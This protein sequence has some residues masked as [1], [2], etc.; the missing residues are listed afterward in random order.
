MS[1]GNTGGSQ[2]AQSGAGR[3]LRPEEILLAVL[4]ALSVGGIAVMNFSTRY[5]LWYWLAMVPTFGGVS[6]YSGWSRARRKGESGPD[7]LRVQLL[8]WGGLVLAVL[9]VY[10]LQ[11]TG[12]LDDDEAGFVALL[13]LSLTTFLAG[14]HFDWRFCV[15]GVV[16]GITLAVAAFVKGFFWLLLI[17]VA[18]AGA[19]AVLWKRRST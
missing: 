3:R 9:L 19:L 2:G 16:L 14:V 4:V 5:G 17:P 15:L 7:I 11:N 6:I 18:V 10:L 8:H 1:V 12:R 13:A